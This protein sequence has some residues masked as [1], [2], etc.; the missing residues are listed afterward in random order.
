MLFVVT[1]VYYIEGSSRTGWWCESISNRTNKSMSSSIPR[2]NKDISTLSSY[3]SSAAPD[4]DFS[5]WDEEIGKIC[6]VLCANNKLPS[7][8]FQSMFDVRIKRVNIFTANLSFGLRE[9]LFA[10][11]E[12][13]NLK[14]FSVEKLKNSLELLSRH[15]FSYLSFRCKSSAR[16]NVMNDLFLQVTWLTWTLFQNIINRNFT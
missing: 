5:A 3:L 2:L 1:K 15:S 6:C 4:Y 7:Q 16:K 12:L 13:R 14:R 11:V 8:Y 9:F 10:S